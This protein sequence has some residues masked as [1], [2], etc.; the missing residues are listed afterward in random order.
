MK[1][2]FKISAS[3]LNSLI[4]ELDVQLVSFSECLLSPGYRLN[5][6]EYESP[7][8]YYVIEGSGVMQYRGAPPIAVNPHTLIIVPPNYSFSLEACEDKSVRECVIVDG[9][10]PIERANSVGTFSAGTRN[11]K[12]IVFCVFLRTLY[13]KSMG[14]F[15]TLSEPV[16]EEFNADDRLDITLRSVMA[17][18]M[19]QEVA[20]GAMTAALLKEIIVTLFRRSFS[21]LTSWAGRVSVL[22]DPQVALAFANMVV[23]PGKAHTIHTLATGACLG[24]STFITRFNSTIG[25]SPMTLLRE[26][27]MRQAALQLQMSNLPVEQI[28][29]NAGYCSRSS[30]VKAFRAS[31]GVDPSTYRDSKPAEAAI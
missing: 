16:V 2:G 21:S 12:T 4:T 30:F 24:R 20:A 26:V 15:E 9:F 14:L 27:R 13:C 28:L 6:K 22:S 11:P 25:Q 3:T 10:D 1:A 29:R 7:C 5:V 18:L 19:S 17:E 31:Y 8:I 23:Q